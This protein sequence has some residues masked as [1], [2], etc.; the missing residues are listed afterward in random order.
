MKIKKKFK[1]DLVI[2]AGGYGSRIKISKGQTKT[3]IKIS[4]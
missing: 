2:L 4:K 3:F 1:T